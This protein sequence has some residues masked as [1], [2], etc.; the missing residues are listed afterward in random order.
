MPSDINQ[1]LTPIDQI[2]GAMTGIDNEQLVSSLQDVMDK[3]NGSANAMGALD[4][5][6]RS[7]TADGKPLSESLDKLVAC[8]GQYESIIGRSSISTGVMSGHLSGMMKPV[9]SV[10]DGL[11]RLTSEVHSL[12]ATAAKM[13]LSSGLDAALPKINA[14][15]D[16]IKHLQGMTMKGVTVNVQERHAGG[17]AV[18]GD[19][20][21]GRSYAK[22][23][24][25]VRY[26]SRNTAIAVSGG[27]FIGRKDGDR[28]MA[29]VNAGEAILTERALK[30]G[31]RQAGMSVGRYVNRLNSGD[32]SSIKKGRSF[33]EGTSPSEPGSKQK[34]AAGERIQRE[35]G[36]NPNESQLNLGGLLKDIIDLLKNI[37]N[38][39][40]KSDDT[41]DIAG[42][43]KDTLSSSKN[44]PMKAGS[45]AGLLNQQNSFKGKSLNDIIADLS[46]GNSGTV[47]ILKNL[48]EDGEKIAKIL[49]GYENKI[50]SLGDAI[51]KV[52]EDNL[53]E[54]QYEMIR[55]FGDG[56]GKLINDSEGKIGKLLKSFGALAIGIKSLGS[57]SSWVSEQAS[58]SAGFDKAAVSAQNWA[59]VTRDSFEKISKGF[60]LTRKQMVDMGSAMSEVG[61]GG[62]TDGSV[63][64][65]MAAGMKSAFGEIDISALKEAAKIFK[66]LPKEQAAAMFA[67]GSFE[68]EAN[69]LTN[70]VNNGQLDQVIELQMKGA[71][72]EK[73]GMAQLSE[74]DRMVVE[75]QQETNKLLDSIDKLMYDFLPNSMAEG[76]QTMRGVVDISKKVGRIM[77]GVA[78]LLGAK[79][80]YKK[81]SSGT[82]NVHEVGSGSGMKVLGKNPSGSAGGSGGLLR[83][84]KT[85]NDKIDQ[86]FRIFGKKI[87][88]KF[89]GKSTEIGKILSGSL[90]KFG[91]KLGGGFGNAFQSGGWG[92]I[93]GQLFKNL[94]GS[95]MKM[96]PQ[97]GSQIAVAILAKIAKNN[98]R[99]SNRLRVRNAIENGNASKNEEIYGNSMGRNLAYDKL[100]IKA[101]SLEGGTKS[102][103][104]FAGAVAAV[105][106]AVGSVIPG[107][108]TLSGAITGL[109]VGAAAGMLAGGVGYLSGSKFSKNKELNKNILMTENKTSSVWDK[110]LFGGRLTG[111]GDLFNFG[112]STTFADR[113]RK[114][115]KDV[116]FVNS[117][118]EKH[119]AAKMGMSGRFK[120]DEKT[121]LAKTRERVDKDGVKVIEYYDKQMKTWMTM[122]KAQ[123]NSLK[124][125]IALNKNV[126][127]IDNIAKGIYS[128][129]ARA[130]IQAHANNITALSTM[131][132]TNK[133]FKTNVQGGMANSIGMWRNDFTALQRTKN[134]TVNDKTMSD[135][136]KAVALNKVMDAELK[137]HQNFIAQMKN[138]VGQVGK[139][140]ELMEREIRE[141]VRRALDDFQSANMVGGINDAFESGMSG[142]VDAGNSLRDTVNYAASSMSNLLGHFE[143]MSKEFENYGKTID[144]QLK[145]LNGGKEFGDEDAQKYRDAQA[146]LERMRSDAGIND[147]AGLRDE[148]N[149]NSNVFGELRKKKEDELDEHDMAQAISAFKALE[150]HTQNALNEKNALGD[151]ATKEDKDM[152]R[153]LKSMLENIKGGINAAEK[154]DKESL[155][156]VI[157]AQGEQGGKIIEQFENTKA[158]T[159]DA[160]LLNDLRNRHPDIDVDKMQTV[161]SLLRAKSG[162]SDNKVAME[163]MKSEEIKS[164][165]TKYEK[166]SKDL[167]S[168]MKHV[169]ENGAVQFKNAMADTLKRRQQ[170]MMAR[171]ESGADVVSKIF[172]S[173]AEALSA[174]AKS[175]ENGRELV[176][177]NLNDLDNLASDENLSK[178]EY[179]NYTT[180]MKEAA[181]LMQKAESARLKALLNPEDTNAQ[182]AAEKAL[183]ARDNAIAGLKG[184]KAEDRTTDA[185][186]LLKTFETALGSETAPIKL[187]VE[188]MT[189]QIEDTFAQWEKI[190]KMIENALAG[191]YPNR[192]ARAKTEESLSKVDY[193]NQFGDYNEAVNESLDSLKFSKESYDMDMKVIE[194]IKQKQKADAKDF[195]DNQIK[196]AGNNQKKIA[197]INNYYNEQLALADKEYYDNKLKIAQRRNKEI[198][199]AFAARTE[200]SE[201]IGKALDIQKDVA[202]SIGA[203]FEFVLQIEQ[204]IVKL[205]REQAKIEEDKLAEMEASGKHG[206]VLEDQ[207]LKVAEAQAKVLKAAFGAQRD[208]LDKML[209]KMMGTFTEVGGIFGPDGARMLARKYGQGYTT[210]E[211]GMAM[212]AGPN[213]TLSYEQRRYKNAG[214]AVGIGSPQ[215]TTDYGSGWGSGNT[216]KNVLQRTGSM[217]GGFAGGKVGGKSTVHMSF[218]D[219]I[220]MFGRTFLDENNALKQ[221]SA[222]DTEL[223]FFKP[224]E[225]II[226]ENGAMKSAMNAGVS[227][228]G[229]ADAYRNGNVLGY[230]A[231]HSPVL[232]KAIDFTRGSFRKM[233]GH[234]VEGHAEGK[235]DGSD[236]NYASSGTEYDNLYADIVKQNKTRA[237]E[238]QNTA[239]Y[240]EKGGVAGKSENILGS[241]GLFSGAIQLANEGEDPMKVLLK[242]MDKMF[243]YFETG[244]N[245]KILDENAVSFDKLDNEIN[246]LQG[247][248]AK[249]REQAFK[250]AGFGEFAQFSDKM[251]S[252]RIAEKKAEMEKA[253]ASGNVEQY[254]RLGN[255]ISIIESLLSISQN[256]KFINRRG[257]RMNDVSPSIDQNVENMAGTN[258]NP[259]VIGTSTGLKED[260]GVLFA[261]KGESSGGDIVSAIES[262]KPSI[263]GIRELLANAFF[264][265]TEKKT[266][267]KT[268]AGDSSGND[269]GDLKKSGG[270]SGGS[271]E[272]PVSGDRSVN[273]HATGMV[274]GKKSIHLPFGKVTKM[275]GSVFKGEKGLEH[276]SSGDT[277]LALFK[278]GEKIIPEKG[279]KQSAKGLGVSD[280]GLADAYR[281][282][283]LAE[284][285]G[286]KMRS[287]GKKMNRAAGRFIRG[288][289]GGSAQGTGVY[290]S[291]QIAGYANGRVLSS[292][293][294]DQGE[295]G[296][297]VD[298]SAGIKGYKAGSAGVS[299]AVGS[300]IGSGA[301]NNYMRVINQT[302][303]R[304]GGVNILGYVGDKLKTIEMPF[305][306]W[307]KVCNKTPDL[308]IFHPG[309]KFEIPPNTTYNNATPIDV[310]IAK[311]Y[312]RR[313][314]GLSI[315][316]EAGISQTPKPS[317]AA[318]SAG[319]ASSVSSTPAIKPNM[320]KPATGTPQSPL[321]AAS[322]A[323]PASPKQATAGSPHAPK[324]I[325]LR[326]AHHHAKPAAGTPQAPKPATTTAPA[327]APKP[328]AGTPQVP[329]PGDVIDVSNIRVMT[330]PDGTHVVVV[331]G[332]SQSYMMS[333]DDYA[334]NYK[335]GNKLTLPKN[336][337]TL[338]TA[339]VVSTDEFMGTPSQG[340]PAGAAG[341]PAMAKPG[342]V[343]KLKNAVEV[344]PGMPGGAEMI[345]VTDANGHAYQMSFEDYANA[346]YDPKTG[347]MVLPEKTL[348]VAKPLKT[349]NPV[350]DM[351]YTTNTKGK[352]VGT[353][354]IPQA[355]S[356]GAGK[357]LDQHGENFLDFKKRQHEHLEKVLKER[358]QQGLTGKSK[359]EYRPDVKKSGKLFGSDGKLNNFRKK[360][361][362]MLNTR[363]GKYVMTGLAWMPTL[364][365]ARSAI[366]SEGDERKQHLA[367]AAIDSVPAIASTLAIKWGGT[368]VGKLAG[369][370]ISPLFAAAEA[371]KTWYDMSHASDEQMQNIVEEW[372]E[373][374]TSGRLKSYGKRA[375]VA[376]SIGMLFGGPM[377]ALAAIAVDAAGHAVSDLIKSHYINKYKKNRPIDINL[378]T[379]NTGS[380]Y[381]FEDI[382]QK[383]KPAA[384][385]GTSVPGAGAP[386]KGNAADKDKMKKA[387]MEKK[388][389]QLDKL[390]RSKGYPNYDSM[391]TSL[392]AEAMKKGYKSIKDMMVARAMKKKKQM[393]QA[394][395]QAAADAYLRQAMG[396]RMTGREAMEFETRSGRYSS[397]KDEIDENNARPG[398]FTGYDSSS[399]DEMAMMS[400]QQQRIEEEMEFL[401]QQDEK[402]AEKRERENKVK[403]HVDLMGG[404]GLSIDSWNRMRVFQPR[405]MNVA[406]NPA[407]WRRMDKMFKN[408]ETGKYRVTAR[409]YQYMRSL[410]IPDDQLEICE[411]LYDPSNPK[412]RKRA[413][414]GLSSPSDEYVK[415]MKNGQ[416]EDDIIPRVVYNPL[417]MNV[418][419][420]ESQKRRIDKSNRQDGKIIAAN[421]NVR[422]Y[423][424]KNG[425]DENDILVYTSKNKNK[426]K[427]E[428]D[429]TPAEQKPKQNPKPAV[430]TV[431]PEND[432]ER[433]KKAGDEVKNYANGGIVGR[434]YLD[435]LRGYADGM[436]G[437]KEMVGGRE[438][439]RIRQMD[440]A[441]LFGGS[442]GGKARPNGDNYFGLFKKGEVIVP[443]DKALQNANDLGVSNIGLAD[444]YRK[445]HLGDF[446]ENNGVFMSGYAKGRN[447][448]TYDSA[449]D[450]HRA[451]TLYGYGRQSGN[452][453]GGLN[454]N[455]TMYVPI[456]A[457]DDGNGLSV[458]PEMISPRMVGGIGGISMPSRGLEERRNGQQSG[459]KD[460]NHGSVD[461][462]GGMDSG[463]YTVRFVVKMDPESLKG[464][465]S[466]DTEKNMVSALKGGKTANHF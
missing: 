303:N 145:K 450:E 371:G 50:L 208:S 231:G 124:Q 176:R 46:N 61:K 26:N 460:A 226:P 293:L 337:K 411:R 166:I 215:G 360:A 278:R 342:D 447:G 221:R 372:D 171:G 424:I 87:G 53:R 89:G 212:A 368:T 13:D 268:D 346:K 274:G 459:G 214:I 405:N 336:A 153:T 245:V 133:S 65:S 290:E 363:A 202:N 294:E 309:A 364:M 135:A 92:G 353:P 359:Q 76:S 332:K 282:G 382:K 344:S 283:R 146:E 139:M 35:F 70:L 126:K 341:R 401:K 155:A 304:A 115:K 435:N 136:Q 246:D 362:S 388:K 138:F 28:E 417:N 375:L 237:S 455:Q 348:K 412:D 448:E 81:V 369:R 227:D 6:I 433:Q 438:S 271:T 430:E 235:V 444:S 296:G 244:V 306:E 91:G 442:S 302:Y 275:F 213:S 12:N 116:D 240:P 60:S 321:P 298:G 98:N 322:T 189:K 400:R 228:T 90:D 113:G 44:D 23:G 234:G 249:K 355:K 66:D 326:L 49:K 182:E 152:I 250:K 3:A 377:G 398:W 230:L 112:S 169:L 367:H 104:A 203:P 279:A 197:A 281:K 83:G 100:G 195:Y 272:A 31:A 154:G 159:I 17:T 93:G 40:N 390:A 314:Q 150:E 428:N 317:A 425:Y 158:A 18:T 103:M 288:F 79:A 334:A 42:W 311:W 406:P 345:Q 394:E 196:Q 224:G 96:G 259:N 9:Q 173:S 414:M 220:D 141:G 263:D 330:Q 340:A 131:G 264:T 170:Y 291:A 75:A 347:N 408:N 207:K 404:V 160:K 59:N 16:R 194:E 198:N 216:L 462:T 19:V 280:Y 335:L 2:Q 192:I 47:D 114:G 27:R 285:L 111:W 421:D 441:G 36:F 258:F 464:A 422:K 222:G 418:P 99:K 381:K 184:K 178:E 157:L 397:G 266:R 1:Q 273:G 333:A 458:S 436:P 105:G 84:P 376:G 456:N 186:E 402:N 78:P 22:G 256:L 120:V 94:S 276:R 420:T 318:P 190:P 432:A 255:E 144:E 71:F 39:K 386:G 147:M 403:Q 465:L 238:T 352:P 7:L 463:N 183:L 265:V 56:F 407:D 179:K 48:K 225:K 392:Q 209:G 86:T 199:D 351:L 164:I 378:E 188:T 297:Y 217:I 151:K 370:A 269:S 457:N 191:S 251:F 373:T 52:G 82:V 329:N 193:I 156:R 380:D 204:N 109:L 409:G 270:S 73:A 257:K 312:E 310:D 313:W 130:T 305:D 137:V 277:E 174:R 148:L 451:E 95:M 210:N 229:L 453:A 57:M 419:L 45:L 123:Q 350:D 88:S 74:K 413:E 127:Q 233:F 308:K 205:A 43:L 63:I 393:Q 319:P 175:I 449:V 445:G 262:L 374:G 32:I 356:G 149:A 292:Y 24:S 434:P 163:T 185:L 181:K 427:Q 110:L 8:F 64:E 118:I 391:M 446:L 68:N 232:K 241:N 247:S 253:K 387:I 140:P 165:I 267:G 206:K 339:K 108:G 25:V 439:Y 168:N 399:P 331:Q 211:S 58:L 69:A 121:G 287:A 328:A 14:V 223:A 41:R 343:I 415:S 134:S 261:N 29:F 443:P 299:T 128:S 323:N 416:N 461:M 200:K 284:F 5:I 454:S 218:N 4:G 349:G 354:Q 54:F 338:K 102:M 242:C 300:E 324:P 11:S 143:R 243:E 34:K 389:Q 286:G 37:E 21:R 254:T 117:Q 395:R 248:F 142:T 365:D 466:G 410:G 97:L 325:D 77:T 236:Q 320:P 119:A 20:K 219:I 72:G 440:I 301:A 51:D 161:L 384:P 385:A 106:A 437:Q 426:E 187:F 10:A 295:I 239:Q 30:R 101:S 62:M 172:Q 429:K 180:D 396:S 379:Q 80:A 383:P 260:T 201:R 38:D 357:P 315:E 361:L 358:K 327:A 366:L 162:A 167:V 423:L 252:E 55:T 289:A 125:L 107:L 307:V 431:N 452:G 129:Y 15:I 122:E 177:K 316:P 33:A 85:F 67:P 132:G